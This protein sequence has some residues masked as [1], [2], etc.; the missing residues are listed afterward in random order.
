MPARDTGDD[1]RR[2][3]WACTVILFALRVYASTRVGFGDSEALYVAYAAHP[4]PAYLDHPG[5]VGVV[6]ACFRGASGVISPL[7]VHLATS[8]VA[9][10]VPWLTVLAARSLGAARG[11]AYV[12][13]LAVAVA[14]ETAVGLFALTP[15]LLLAPTWLATIA[16]LGFGLR[17]PSG[18][19]RGAASLV[20]AGL[21]A[22]VAAASKVSGALLVL[23]VAWALVA[24]A[25][26]QASPARGWARSAWP[27]LGLAAGAAISL[28]VALWELTRG[29]PMLTHRIAAPGG[30]SLLHAALVTAGQLAYVSP[31]LLYW[32]ALAARSLRSQ[33]GASV[34]HDVGWRTFALPAVVLLALSWLSPRSEPHWIAPALLTLAVAAGLDGVWSPSPKLGRRALAVAAAVTSL[35]FAW[36]LVP[37]SSRF[38]PR[39]ADLRWDIASELYGWPDVAGRVRQERASLAA[40]PHEIVVVGPHWT[41]CAQIAAAMPDVQVGC[42]TP[43]GDDFDDWM[44]RARWR[45]APYVVWVTDNRFAEDGAGELPLHAVRSRTR[46][47]IERG[48]RVARVF[49]IVIYERRAVSRAGGMGLSPASA[50]SERSSSSSGLG[51][52][53]SLSP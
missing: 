26:S 8:V 47:Q 10:A 52:V 19:T 16:L 37:Q 45:K 42:A 44:P 18:S 35:A 39:Q 41:V 28:P 29:H 24:R 22:G 49:E 1:A 3:L 2:A 23:A 15:D 34:A 30:P 43:T 36:V 38:V 51:V 14:P 12:A 27:W 46:V 7:R 33:R 13:G 6:A 53:S 5:M 11:R 48:G 25:R 50:S 32:A 31:L 4:Q 9:S 40:E 21:S 17:A 20:G